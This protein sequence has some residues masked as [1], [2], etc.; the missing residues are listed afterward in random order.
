[1]MRNLDVV[2]FVALVLVFVGGA[3]FAYGLALNPPLSLE[4]YMRIQFGDWAPGLII[5]G[6]LLLTINRVIHSH[7]RKRVISQVA[8]LSNEFALDA[9]RRCRNEGWLQNG[10]MTGM[11]FEGANLDS[12]DLSDSNLSE[13][14]FSFAKLSGVD[15]THANLKGINLKGANLQGADLRWADL[16]RASLQWADLRNAN[17]TGSR[18]D[19]AKADF[20]LVDKAHSSIQELENSVVD[21]YISERQIELVTSTFHEFSLVGNSGAIRFYERLFETAPHLSKL[22]DNDVERQAKMFLQALSVIVNSLSSTER[23][24][25]VLKRLGDIHH[26]YGVE[27]DHYTLLGTALIETIRE[28]LGDN[29]SDEANEAW[30]AAFRLISSVMISASEVP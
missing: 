16:S 22:F 18:L 17:L 27:P 15:L 30:T 13:T 12:A 11:S 9:V 19:G 14:D 2:D 25:R 20:A 26:S 28:S 6:I 10:T 29:F 4:E 1:M 8:S 7:E 21:G 23:A 24:A 3:L 5:D